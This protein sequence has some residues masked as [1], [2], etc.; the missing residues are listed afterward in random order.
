VDRTG[1]ES[2]GDGL[3]PEAPAPTRWPGDGGPPPALPGVE[4]GRILALARC[5]P[6]AGT[7]AGGHPAWLN[8]KTALVNALDRT[9]PPWS[10]WRPR[11]V[12]QNYLLVR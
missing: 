12:D 7:T 2:A 3:D 8:G 1:E 4:G 11:P 10:T 5:G 6:V 9:R